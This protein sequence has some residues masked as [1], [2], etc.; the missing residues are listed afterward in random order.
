MFVRRTAAAREPL[1][2]GARVAPGDRLT[3]ELTV[4]RAAWA[5]VLNEDEH[6]ERWLLFPQPRDRLP[7][8]R[9]R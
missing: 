2:D 1:A 6:G 8:G 3:F 5:Y 4:T 7:A 9:R